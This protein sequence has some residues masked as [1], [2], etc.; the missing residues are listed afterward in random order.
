M[1]FSREEAAA[2]N[3]NSTAHGYLSAGIC[4]PQIWNILVLG[5]EKPGSCLALFHAAAAAINSSFP[6][7]SIT[8]GVGWEWNRIG[9]YQPCISSPL[10]TRKEMRNKWMAD[11]WEG[12]GSTTSTPFCVHPDEYP[13]SALFLLLFFIIVLNLLCSVLMRTIK[14]A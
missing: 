5:K 11:R 1:L 7:V 9:I 13:L 3:S 2:A 12:K 4:F 14:S 10:E 6:G 8:H